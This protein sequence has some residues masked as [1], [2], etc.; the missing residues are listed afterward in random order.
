MCGFFDLSLGAIN[1]V[2]TYQDKQNGG[3]FCSAKRAH[4][5]EGLIDFNATS[6]AG[7]SIALVFIC[8]SSRPPEGNHHSEHRWIVLLLIIDAKSQKDYIAI[9]IS[10][11][12]S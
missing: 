10:I 1:K 3:F 9:I 12:E 7:L 6:L 4:T 11:Q 8:Y 2:L 5:E